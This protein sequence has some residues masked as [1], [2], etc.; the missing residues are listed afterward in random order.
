MVSRDLTIHTIGHGDHTIE[1]F[2]DLLCR[3]GITLVVDVRSQPYSRWVPQF[4][5]ELLI[6]DLHHAGIKYHYMGNTLGGRPA[7]PSLYD[8]G[9]DRP[10]YERVE[11]TDDYQ[12]GIV[13]LLHLVR[14]T[15]TAIMCSEGDYHHCHRHLLVT[16]TLLEHGMRVLHIQPDGTTVP[17]SQIPRQLSLFG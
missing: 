15:P 6:H 11:Q 5:R 12:A 16:Q 9:E 8:T 14:D 17:A 4:N 10:D 2:I 1:G 3:Y 7:D 13:E